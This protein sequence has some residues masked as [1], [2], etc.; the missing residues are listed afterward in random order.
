MLNA[1]LTQGLD[2]LSRD[3]VI[4]FTKY[5]RYVLPLDGYVFW[6]ATEQTLIRGSLHVAVDE[7]QSED[8]TLDVNHVVFTTDQEVDTFNQIGPDTILVG[9]WRD[10][11]F[12][13][14]RR[15]FYYENARIFH[16]TGEAVYPAM[17]S[18]LV[19]VGSEFP[20]DTLI[21]SNSLPAWLMIK[22]YT[23]IWLSPLNPCVTLY[24]SFAVPDNLRPPYGAVHIEPGGTT[25]LQSIPLLSRWSTHDQLAMD[26]VRVT[27][28]GLTNSQ[29]M[30]WYDTVLRYSEDQGIIGLMSDPIVRDEKRGQVGLDIL[31]M[32]KVISFDVSYFQARV[33]DIARQ[34]IV[35]A[36]AAVIPRGVL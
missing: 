4:P 25:A 6:L 11:R 15:G 23:P 34:L 9:E 17:E 3:E 8:E 16:Y 29:A 22:S 20:V 33:N 32:K 19:D 31:A 18:Q 7:R 2:T 30:D 27:L 12:A 21:V 1:P 28:Y 35:S 36:A 5:I 14:S 13:F 24:P 10:I 26:R